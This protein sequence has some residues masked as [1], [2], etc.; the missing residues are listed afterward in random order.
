MQLLCRNDVENFDRWKEVLDADHEARMH[1][2]LSVLQ[3]WRDADRPNRVWM[4]FEVNDRDRAQAFMDDLRAN[5]QRKR[6]GVTDGEYHFV[7]TL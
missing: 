7:D 6:A 3:L 2:G 5:E 1:A 4:L